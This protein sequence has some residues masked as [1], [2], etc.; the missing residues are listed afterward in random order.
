ME[1]K[2]FY[3]DI[4]V[5]LVTNGPRF[6]IGIVLFFAGL[7]FIKFLRT[8][9]TSR[10]HKHEVHSSLRPFFL[11]L[12][13]TALYVLLVISVL[14]VMGYPITIFATLV[15]ALGVAAG[16]ALSG[17]LQNFAGG[18]LILLLKPFDVEDHIIAQGQDGRV[19]GIQLFYT[20]ILTADNKTVIIPNGKL[21]NEVITNITRQGKRRLDIDFKLNYGADIEQVKGIINNAIKQT[22][23]ILDEPA[24][25]V[26]VLTLDADGMHFTIRVWVDPSFFLHT[27][28]ALQEKVVNDV[29]AAGIKLPG[30][31]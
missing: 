28:I 1:L 24:S 30:M 13:I 23:N 3:H 14:S 4:H 27:K 19:Q 20:E 2:E 18:V 17:T 21:F 8:K 16:L 11:S 5:W 22:P 25:R 10:M 29:K 31:A 12:S 26:G 7:W 15:G 9:L 6:I